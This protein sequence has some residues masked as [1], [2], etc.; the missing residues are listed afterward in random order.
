M[1]DHCQ[2][3][4]H[5]HDHHSSLVAYRSS[6]SGSSRRSHLQRRDRGL[7]QSHRSSLAV[8][9]LWPSL[10]S[11]LFRGFAALAAS[12]HSQP[13]PCLVARCRL[14]RHEAGVAAFLWRP[15]QEAEFLAQEQER[16]LDRCGCHVLSKGKIVLPKGQEAAAGKAQKIIKKTFRPFWIFFLLFFGLSLGPRGFAKFRGKPFILQGFGFAR[17]FF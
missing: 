7:G 17:I 2:H 5:E 8:P 14:E 9:R 11:L 3:H 16:I 15:K 13:E 1:C 4:D 10:S 12:S 6:C